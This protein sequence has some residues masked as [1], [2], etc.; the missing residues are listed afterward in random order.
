MLVP[1][2]SSLYVPGETTKLDT[3][4]V[5]VG[6]G[7][8]LEKSLPEAQAFLD[9]KIHLIMGQAGK[10]GQALQIKQQ[11]L[12]S[13]VQAMNAKIMA[14]KRGALSKR[15]HAPRAHAAVARP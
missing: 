2:T 5:D 4:L 7:Y 13:T 10:V 12:Q 8:Y 9:R 11:G 6:T 14:F 3:V 1:V 15:G